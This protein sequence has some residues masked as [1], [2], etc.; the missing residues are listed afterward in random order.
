MLTDRSKERIYPIIKP[1]QHKACRPISFIVVRFSDEY[2]FNIL[3]SECIRNPINELITIDNRSNLFFKNLTQ[4]ISAGVTRAHHDIII[5]VHEDVLLPRGWQDLFEESLSSLEMEDKSWGVLGSVGWTAD[6]KMVG[7]WSDPHGYINTLE[8]SSYHPV[9]RLDEQILIFHRQTMRAFD[10]NL[11]GIHFLGLDIALN[12]Q[13]HGLK[14]YAINAPTIHKYADQDNQ[15]IKSKLDSPKIRARETLRFKADYGC[16][17][18]YIA[19]KWYKAKKITYIAPASESLCPEPLK[20]IISPIVF[21]PQDTNCLKLLNIINKGIDLY[22]GE[23]DNSHEQKFVISIFKGIIEK[24]HCSQE[25]QNAQIIPRIKLS[26]QHLLSNRKDNH[27]LWGFMVVE[28]A[29]LIAEIIRAFPGARFIQVMRDPLA[30]AVDES[31]HQSGLDNVIDRIVVPIAYE[32]FNLPRQRILEDSPATRKGIQALYQLQ[33]IEENIPIAKKQDL[34][35][36]RYE[37]MI[38]DPKSS[39]LSIMKWLGCPIPEHLSVEAT[40]IKDLTKNNL[41]D[42]QSNF[43]GASDLLRSLRDRY[44]Y[45]P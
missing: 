26:A 44:G 41:L 10:H 22:T 2:L 39:L 25:W 6:N 20:E 15:L 34:L 36:L 9:I 30:T 33:M 3:K 28:S 37:N 7:H 42:T 12:L 29:V 4:A 23:R 45:N 31:R 32:Y 5:V 21:L 13:K 43:S 1:I 35:Q 38:S 14:S 27:S 18:D 8:E 24:Y 40:T 16:C 11:P 19:H 17:A